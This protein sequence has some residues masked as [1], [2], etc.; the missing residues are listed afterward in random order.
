MPAEIEY[1]EPVASSRYSGIAVKLY[2]RPEDCA[3]HF[4][5]RICTFIDQNNAMNNFGIPAKRTEL[6]KSYYKRC[7]V[8]QVHFYIPGIAR[9]I[10]SES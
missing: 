5:Q 1:V 10:A 4:A 9:S 2:D 8:C 3:D 7:L 6:Q